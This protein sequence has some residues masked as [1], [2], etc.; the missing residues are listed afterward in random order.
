MILP[1]MKSH[2]EAIEKA[3]AVFEVSPRFYTDEKNTGLLTMEIPDLDA[4]TAW[5]VA[6]Q[7]QLYLQI[8]TLD[9]INKDNDSLFNCFKIGL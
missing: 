4:M 8:E 1:V 6:E 3:C 2:R 7:A 9:R 5:R